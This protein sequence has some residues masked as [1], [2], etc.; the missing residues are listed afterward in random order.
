MAEWDIHCRKMD[1]GTRRVDALPNM[2]DEGLCHLKKG[3][4]SR[5]C[6]GMRVIRV[7]SIGLEPR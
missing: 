2:V 5:T 3:R 6:I 4:F 1:R 7:R